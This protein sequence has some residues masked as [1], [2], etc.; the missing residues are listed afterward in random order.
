MT[1]EPPRPSGGGSDDSVRGGMSIAP[2]L[3]TVSHHSYPKVDTKND[4]PRGQKTVTST[5]VGPAEYYELSSDKGRPTGGERPA[6][7]LEPLSRGKVQRHAGMGYE[8]VQN[9]D[10]PVLQMVEQLPNV[11]QFFATRLPVVAEPV[12]E[13]PKILPND[14]PTRRLC[15]DTQ[16][17]EQLVEVPTI[18]SCSLLQRT[19]E[20]HVDIPV[21]GRGG[22]RGRERRTR[23]WPKL[24]RRPGEGSTAFHGAEHQEI[25]GLQGLLPGQR[26]M[27]E[28]ERK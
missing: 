12:I 24:E 15:R 17:A 22:R 3:A 23:L 27:K 7:L 9:L 20:Q 4:A 6:A 11:I 19:M 25:Q 1:L 16:L 26:K 10:F 5:R 21:P 18:V 8:I 2:E 28:N 14:V 13:V